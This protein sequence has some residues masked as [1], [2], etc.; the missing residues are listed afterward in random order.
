M[1]EKT[2]TGSW[3]LRDL[4]VIWHPYTQALTAPPP[5]PIV[6]GEGAYLYGASGEAYLDAISS[7]W[8]NLHGHTHP[9]IARA[10][11]DQAKTLEHVLFGGCTHPQ[12]ILF[13]ER[14]LALL[15]GYSKVFYSDNGS[16]AIE[17]ALKMVFQT[18]DK[19][20]LSFEGAYH[21]DTFGAM[22]AVG[23]T[24][25]NRP[26]WPYLFPVDSIP[27]PEPGCEEASWAAF[28]KALQ[29]DRIGAFIFEPLIQGSGGMRLHSGE[30]LARMIHA[31]RE[32]GILTI[33]DEV[34][35]AFG[36][37]GPLF[38]CSRLGIWPDLLCLSKGIT[39]GFL[40]L[41]ATV[42]KESIFNAFLSPDPARALLHGHSYMA[43][44]LACAAA[45]A[46]LDL[47]LRPE[48]EEARQRI[49]RSHQR[50][51]SKWAGHPKLR[52][53]DVLGTIFALEYRVEDASY[54]NPLKRRLA[55][56][57][58]Q[59]GILV[60]PLGNVLY[61][62]PPYCIQDDELERIYAVIQETLN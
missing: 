20:L 7:W 34:M 60:R 31:C 57:F 14:L 37:T 13:A 12:A 53:V 47:L 56:L 28:E 2:D 49:E 42:V 29:S 22:A 5:I 11:A 52:R 48:C 51:K 35:T 33:A 23:K 41:G 50:A 24:H 59:R 15:P 43:N 19:G 3:A 39:G 26:F 40:P 45:N 36:R 17:I 55:D 44:P 27:P 54:F 62:L 16:T 58:L 38:A 25:F 46:N 6:R 61:L 1:V 4:A 10:I 9:M 32:R 21:G 18:S 8:V 30:V